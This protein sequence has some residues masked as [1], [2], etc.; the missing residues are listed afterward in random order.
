MPRSLCRES[1]RLPR[2]FRGSLSLSRDAP[3]VPRAS[4]RQT[5]GTGAVIGPV[6]GDD[7]GRGARRVLRRSAP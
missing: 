4:P 5:S 3:A 1:D 2:M 6:V 7:D